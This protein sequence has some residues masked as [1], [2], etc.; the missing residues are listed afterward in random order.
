M[1]KAKKPKI[2]SEQQAAVLAAVAAHH[3]PDATLEDLAAQVFVNP[4]TG[5]TMFVP[6][7]GKPAPSAKEDK[8]AK[9]DKGTDSDDE[10][11]S[12][13]SGD[14]KP[15]D[16]NAETG[17]GQQEPPDSKPKPATTPRSPLLQ[18]LGAPAAKKSDTLSNAD[19][20]DDD[21]FAAYMDDNAEE[22]NYG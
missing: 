21:K 16:S 17:T 14:D 11:G 6:G 15:A 7:D 1:A 10:G 9:D 4:V 12:D 3:H 8:T 5:Q 2:S 18:A 22:F 20:M 19:V 13:G